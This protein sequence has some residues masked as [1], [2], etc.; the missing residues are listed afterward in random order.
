MLVLRRQCRPAVPSRA[1]HPAAAPGGPPRRVHL[2]LCEPPAPRR[3]ARSGAHMH[4][5]SGA[6]PRVRGA[7]H[8]SHPGEARAAHGPLRPRRSPAP[9][10]SPRRASF[11]RRSSSSASRP[12]R[13]SSKTPDGSSSSSTRRRATPSLTSNTRSSLPPITR[14][15]APASMSSRGT[16]SSCSEIVIRGNEHT[17]DSTIRERIAL[18]IGKPYRTSDLA[19]DARA[20]RDLERLFEHRRRARGAVRPAEEQDGHRDCDRAEPAR[21]RGARRASRRGKDSAESST[22]RTRTSAATP[23]ASACEGASRTSPISHLR[24]GRKAELRF[25]LQPE[26]HQP[27]HRLLQRE[28]PRAARSRPQSRSPRSSALSISAPSSARRLTP[29]ACTTSSTTSS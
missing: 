22:T 17:N 27:H 1:V 29:S 2:R 19:E 25:A 13:S 21:D 3:A 15:R 16:R 9:E 26:R 12:T 20:H 28:P 4:A 6:R 18:E 10:R 7:G 5:R 11:A 23:S 14:A 8:A 24:P